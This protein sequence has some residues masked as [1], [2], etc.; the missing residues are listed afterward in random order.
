[1]DDVGFAFRP[2]Q[3]FDFPDPY[4]MFAALRRNQPV[5]RAETVNRVSYVVSRYDDVHAV[6]RDADLFS[7]RANSEVGKYMGRT[8]IEMDGKEHARMRALITSVF[9][10][11]S[12]DAMSTRVEHLTHTLIDDF[13][14]DGRANLVEQFTMLLPIQVIA[15]IV[16]VPRADYPMFKDVSFKLVG[17][18]R[19]PA[20]GLEASR[21]LREYLEPFIAARRA[22]PRDDV[23]SKLVTG[24]I[25][26]AGLTDEE[27]VSFLRLLI[28]AGAETTAR[29]IGS[30]LFALLVERE[31]WERVRA[32]RSLIRWAIDETLRWETPVVFVAREATRDTEIAGVPI[33]ARNMVSAILGSANRD[34]THYQRPDDFDLDRRAVD[35]VSFGF[36]QHFCLGSHLARL[37]ARTAL[38]ALFDR[39]PRARIDPDALPPTVSGL[40]FRSPQA[41]PIRLD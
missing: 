18:P 39:L 21:T 20:A 33:P 4:P 19:D 25:E 27:I 29:L 14:R 38:G 6:L 24:T 2:E 28:P 10:P 32:D 9:T 22:D 23:I 41:L 3:M 35:H 12:I 17:F 26:G 34:E 8:I 1:M 30:M 16:G 36:G 5:L 37:E 31:R 11:R 13:A 40:V 15:D 7:S